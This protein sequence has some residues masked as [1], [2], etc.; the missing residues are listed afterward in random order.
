MIQNCFRVFFLIVLAFSL[1]A[2]FAFAQEMQKTESEPAAEAKVEAVDIGTAPD[3]KAIDNL[4]K[5]LV[6]SKWNG[7]FTIRGKDDKLHVEEYE[8]SS[9]KKEPTGDAWVL[10]TKIKYMKKDFK[11]AVP[12]YIK[13]IDRT[14]MIV[15]DQVTLPGAGTFDARVIIRKGMYAG[16][17]AHGEIGGHLF[18]EITTATAA[19]EKAKSEEK[20]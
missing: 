5:F 10:M 17:W 4:E 12:L 6:G 3:Q 20:K 2:D 18:G 14:P 15:L 16:T 13:W 11:V 19:A 1:Q 9:A 7:T 8:V